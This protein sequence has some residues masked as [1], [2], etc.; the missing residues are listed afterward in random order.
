MIESK[1]EQVREVIAANIAR[2]GYHGY[3]VKSGG[4]LPAYA[5]TISLTERHGYGLIM[6]GVSILS[7][8]D[9]F[10][11]IAMAAKIF[12]EGA[13][14]GASAMADGLVRKRFCDQPIK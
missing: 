4:Q 13:I 12:E 1:I 3:F 6:A 5:Y 10:D 7:A 14:G 11:V 2:Y 8:R 9:T